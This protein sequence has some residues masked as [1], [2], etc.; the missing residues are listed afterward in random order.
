[1]LIPQV[2]SNPLGEK[3]E[4]VV[5]MASRR[6]SYGAARRHSKVSGAEVHP[7]NRTR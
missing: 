7:V 6:V 2:R 1:M 5:L 4:G 3:R